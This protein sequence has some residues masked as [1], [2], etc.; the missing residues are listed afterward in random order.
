MAELPIQGW[1]VEGARETEKVARLEAHQAALNHNDNPTKASEQVVAD[2]MKVVSAHANRTTTL[3]VASGVYRTQESETMTDEQQPEQGTDVDQL[4]AKVADLQKIG[5]PM[6]QRKAAQSALENAL[7][8]E[9]REIAATRTAAEQ[10][11]KEAQDAL[12]LESMAER[13]EEIG[14]KQARKKAFYDKAAPQ[15]EWYE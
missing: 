13:E 11:Q 6:S 1:T 15:K 9:Q 5:A 7:G 12:K 10:V 2:K 3:E 8:A 14:G 4:S